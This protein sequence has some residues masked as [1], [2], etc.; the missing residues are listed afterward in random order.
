VLIPA[1]TAL[2]AITVAACGSNANT[3]PASN[4]QPRPSSV[5]VQPGPTTSAPDTVDLPELND[6]AVRKQFVCSFADGYFAPPQPPGEN[7]TLDCGSP[8]G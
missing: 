1:G 2:L 4:A 5:I 8:T 3:Q 6:P 7:S